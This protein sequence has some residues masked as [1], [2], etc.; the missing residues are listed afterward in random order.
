[1]EA[2]RAKSVRQTTYFIDLW[3]AMLAP[4]GFRLQSPREADRRGSHVALGHDEGLA[5]NLA[6]IHEFG[7]LPDFRPPDTIRF[8]IAPLYT[9]FT[10]LYDTVMALATIVTAK[11]YEPYR[12]VRPLVT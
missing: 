2:V 11:R 4:L 8:G 12:H 6:L 7:I 1:M 10:D 5:I 9:S 3:E